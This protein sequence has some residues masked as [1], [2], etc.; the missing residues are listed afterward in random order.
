[1]V[2]LLSI[3]LALAGTGSYAADC[4]STVESAS[5]LP[6]KLVVERVFGSISTGL[7]FELR[8]TNELSEPLCIVTSGG[9]AGLGFVHL[10]NGEGDRSATCA[11]DIHDPNYDGFSRVS[12]DRLSSPS[13]ILEVRPGDSVMMEADFPRETL[14]VLSSRRCGFFEGEKGRNLFLDGSFAA[15]PCS[16]ISDD[17][18]AAFSTALQEA[19]RDGIWGHGCIGTTN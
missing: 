2:K 18:A 17:A 1:M 14:Q 13:E 12:D 16:M 11:S 7:R 15:I 9:F 8:L 3:L 6:G 19:G 5:R 10:R 4:P